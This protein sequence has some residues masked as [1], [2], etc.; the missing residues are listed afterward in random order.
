VLSKEGSAIPLSTQHSALSTQHSALIQAAIDTDPPG[1]FA[2]TGSHAGPLWARGLNQNAV[3]HTF[4]PGAVP[5][6]NATSKVVR[7]V[8]PSNFQSA[9]AAGG[10]PRRS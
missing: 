5:G 10:R 3:S 4:A 7:V 8:F 2:P 9:M 6:S 1:R